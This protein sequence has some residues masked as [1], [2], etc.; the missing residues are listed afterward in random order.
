MTANCDCLNS[1]GDDPAV[2]KGATTPCQW[3]AGIRAAWIDNNGV[4]TFAQAMCSRLEQ[5]RAEGRGGWYDPAQCTVEYLAALLI[6]A[7]LK[8]N[9]VDVANFAMM[10][11]Q[12]RAGPAVITQALLNH[13]AIAAAPLQDPGWSGERGEC[14]SA[15][16]EDFDS[17]TLDELLDRNDHLRPGDV[18]YVGESRHPD[19]AKYMDA[20]GVLDEV[21]SQGYD[22]GGKY[23]ED[24]PGEVSEEAKS[25]LNGFLRSWLR[26][27]CAPSFYSVPKSRPYTLTA[28]DFATTDHLETGHG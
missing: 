19:P 5:K 12:R 24:Y 8:G 28:A 14:W 20:D 1:C 23:A 6:G 13:C 26:T 25:Q 9:A 4:N 11:H 15:N 22:D 10:L 21:A 27:H 16:D 2:A 3:H 17:D 18:V 7:I